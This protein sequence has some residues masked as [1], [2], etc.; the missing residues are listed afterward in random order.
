MTK[1]DNLGAV[2]QYLKRLTIS[3]DEAEFEYQFSSHPD[4]PSLLAVSDA[5]RF[6]KV[7]N[8]AFKISNEQIK[9]SCG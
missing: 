9:W 4:Y 8:M 3:I 1:K 6:F 2:F 7:N 5:L